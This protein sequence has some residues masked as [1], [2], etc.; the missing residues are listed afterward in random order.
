MRFTIDNGLRRLIPQ[1]SLR[2]IDGKVMVP[3]TLQICGP[4][5]IGTLTT[6]SFRRESIF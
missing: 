2:G 4:P 1:L 6:Q 5:L 3:S